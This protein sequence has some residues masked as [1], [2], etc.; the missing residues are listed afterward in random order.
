MYVVLIG[1]K[2][3]LRIINSSGIILFVEE[4]L[5][6]HE[7]A[8]GLFNSLMVLRSPKDVTVQYVDLGE[9]RAEMTFSLNAEIFRLLSLDM[10]DV[11]SVFYLD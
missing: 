1:R 5:Q 10:N 9:G 4:V 8:S 3:I 7:K 11:S 6:I 2:I